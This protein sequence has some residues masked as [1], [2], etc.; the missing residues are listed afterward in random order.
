MII[1]SEAFDRLVDAADEAQDR[2]E[3][4]ATRAENDYVPWTE[5]KAMLGLE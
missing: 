2:R 1:D 3:L 4:A 5:V